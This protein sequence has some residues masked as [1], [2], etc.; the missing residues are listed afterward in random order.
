MR[1]FSLQSDDII[2]TNFKNVLQLRI[3]VNMAPRVLTFHIS[4]QVKLIFLKIIK[5][6]TIF[7]SVCHARNKMSINIFTFLFIQQFRV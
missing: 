7:F 2:Y 5:K 4:L 1:Q 3:C 6:K